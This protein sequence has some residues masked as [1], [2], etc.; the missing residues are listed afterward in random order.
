[1]DLYILN[2]KFDVIGVIDNAASIIWA[3]KYADMGDFEIY[4]NATNDN[5]TLLQPGHYVKRWDDDMVGIIKKVNLTTNIEDG[6][7]ITVS[8]PDLKDVLR[9]RIIW[10]QTILSGTIADCITKLLD[11]NILNPSNPMRKISNFKITINTLPTD[12]TINKQITGDNLLDAIIEL[13]NIVGYG[14]KVMLNEDKQIEFV[15]YEGV[16]YSDSQDVNPRVIFSPEFDNLVD[17]E[18]EF[19]STKFANVALVAGEGEGTERKTK[20]IGDGV[21]LDRYELYVDARNLSTNSGE[22][23]DEEYNDQ[24]QQKGFEELVKCHITEEFGGEVIHNLTYEYK[25]DY[26]LGDIVTV[27]NEYGLRSNVRIIEIIENE[28]QAG[29]KI[30]PTFSDWRLI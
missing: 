15:L 27:E 16:N 30:L 25:K 14:F 18:Y 24:L 12:M 13:C 28:D 6:N 21:G 19:D 1:M 17:T 2:E 9:R 20:S 3:T 10:S 22:I 29:Y 7:Y 26:Q 11:E 23:T 5:I 8:G 4:A